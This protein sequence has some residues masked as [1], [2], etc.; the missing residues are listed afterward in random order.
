MSALLRRPETATLALLILAIAAGTAL[1]PHFLDARFILQSATLYAEI[2][3]V[4]L[5]L[6]LVMVTGEIDLSVASMTGL[7]ACVFALAIDGGAPAPIA[8]A[9]ALAAGLAMGLCNAALIVGLG[10]PSLIT[11]IGTL[12]LYRGVAQALLGDR[13]VTRFP[14][15]WVGLDS[16]APLGLPAPVWIL[17]GG[18]IVAGAV[19]HGTVFGRR[20]Q[21]VG[22]NAEAARRSGTSVAAVKV[23]L[24]AASG[25]VSAVAGLMMASRLGVVRHDLALGGELQ[26]VLI[27]ILGGVAVTGGRGTIGGVFLAFWLM[28]A[29]QTAMNLANIPAERQLAVL[30]VLLLAAVAA[31]VRR[32]TFRSARS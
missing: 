4:A 20:I 9:E 15:G 26:A 18:A 7:S 22:V 10:L 14:E 11:T 28:V 31:G 17:C 5:A 25:L 13:S 32:T 29:V 27:A 16:I 12:T 8:V 30:G 24:L 1:S 2:G 23:S 6:A 21:L 19:L 3:L